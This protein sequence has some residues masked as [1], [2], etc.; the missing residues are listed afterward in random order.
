MTE[1]A[2]QL[3]GE[4]IALCDLVK[5]AGIATSGGGGKA[6]VASGAVRVDGIVETR[7]TCKIRA[8]QLITVGK[9]GI[10][11][12]AAPAAEIPVAAESGAVAEIPVAAES[13]AVA[14]IAAVAEAPVAADAPAAAEIPAV[15][16]T[17]AA[18][19]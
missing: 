5:I 18:L 13:A 10:R 8:G 14:E 6:L 11:V 4:H 17:P 12:L 19:A 9:V 2:V 1:I 7:K 3:K 16:E 15:A